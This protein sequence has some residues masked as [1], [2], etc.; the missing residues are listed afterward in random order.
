MLG[1]LFKR[2]QLPPVPPTNATNTNSNDN[3][4]E[5]QRQKIMANQLMN[6]RPLVPKTHPIINDYTIT[7]KVLGLGINGKVV[8]CFSRA[9]GDKFALKVSEL[10]CKLVPPF[11]LAT[12]RGL[13]P[14][15]SYVLCV[16]PRNRLS[17]P[18][19]FVFRNM[20]LPD[21]T[22]DQVVWQ[23][24]CFLCTC[25]AYCFADETPCSTRLECCS[26]ARHVSQNRTHL[27]RRDAPRTL[28]CTVLA[29]SKMGSPRV[30]DLRRERMKRDFGCFWHERAAIAC[31]QV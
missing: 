20:Y 12:V 14:M 8:E 27:R 18:A 15:R 30:N 9:A 6:P 23:W 7:D 25:C 13:F 1:S 4:N 3:L 22:Q 21:G 2:R 31:A 19:L 10:T 29:L 24:R 17:S 16:H 11:A 26:C 5:K 28:L